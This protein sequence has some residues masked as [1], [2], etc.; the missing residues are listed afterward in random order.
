M[1][2]AVISGVEVTCSPASLTYFD[3]PPNATCGEYAGSWANRTSA[4][5]LNPDARHNCE[6]CRYTTGD[7]FLA[8]LNLGPGHLVGKWGCWA[9]FVLFTLV[10]LF[11]V[12][13][14]TWATKVK[15]WKLFYF[16]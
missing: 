9:I 14:F 6:V 2:T 8:E 3:A 1:I 11:L 5:L 16:F 7:Q 10:N 13:F 4:K 15:R 12:Y